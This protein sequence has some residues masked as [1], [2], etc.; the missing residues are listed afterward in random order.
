MGCS[1]GKIIEKKNPQL[2]DSKCPKDNYIIK[3]CYLLRDTKCCLIEFPV[4]EAKNID[5]ETCLTKVKFLE[6]Y[7]PEAI[8]R[9][10]LEAFINADIYLP[11]A[12]FLESDNVTERVNIYLKLYDIRDTIVITNKFILMMKSFYRS[13]KF[14]QDFEFKIIKKADIDH[15]NPADNLFYEKRHSKRMKGSKSP[16]RDSYVSSVGDSCD[17]DEDNNNVR[18]VE[19]LI[20]N[21]NRETINKK[22]QMTKASSLGEIFPDMD[23]KKKRKRKISS[24]DRFDKI[25][26]IKVPQYS[27]RELAE[28]AELWAVVPAHKQ[29]LRGFFF[30]PYDYI[31]DE[32]EYISLFLVG[33]ADDK[34]KQGEVFNF[35]TENGIQVKD[36]II[37]PVEEKSIARVILYKTKSAEVFLAK[38]T[39]NYFIID[40]KKIL[41]IIIN[42]P[43][44]IMPNPE[45]LYKN[46]QVN[47]ISN[48]NILSD[49]EDIGKFIT[50]T[51]GEFLEV[52][53][54]TE[55]NFIITFFSYISVTLSK[56]MGCL[57]YNSEIKLTFKPAE[58]PVPIDGQEY[59]IHSACS[60]LP[61][62]IRQSIIID[63]D[64]IP[65]LRTLFHKKTM[66]DL[67]SL[68]NT[69]NSSIMSI[70]EFI[71]YSSSRGR[72]SKAKPQNNLFSPIKHSNNVSAFL[73][74]S[75]IPKFIDFDEK[76]ETNNNINN[77]TGYIN[78]KHEPPKKKKLEF[79]SAAL[80]FDSKFI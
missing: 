16:S 6:A 28:I 13:V 73:N 54:M 29:N 61:Q 48:A 43:I 24:C 33:F 20:D 10:V 7:E 40:R 31:N 37:N 51:F 46:L 8:F 69:Y 27:E 79:D 5:C 68:K 74:A 23:K 67:F 36:L 72:V 65:S 66:W 62:Q 55:N 78:V 75:E 64:Y 80:N 59:T 11:N 57:D 1:Q 32:S 19:D 77:S 35:F 12:I 15:F 34:I 3:A 47:V 58:Y 39:R 42:K 70:N 44:A 45:D 71:K 53:I 17:D 52:K 25:N 56:E 26:D 2:F 76:P 41:F 30:E 49:I 18:T 60:E 21:L 38:N 63:K 50:Q 14:S 22:L 9:A 4:N